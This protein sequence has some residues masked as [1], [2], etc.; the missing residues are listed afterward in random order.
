MGLCRNFNLVLFLASIYLLQ[1]PSNQSFLGF[2]SHVKILSALFI[3]ISLQF[4]HFF[5]SISITIFFYS[6]FSYFK[7]YFLAIFFCHPFVFIQFFHSIFFLS[8]CFSLRMFAIL[9]LYF[10]VTIKWSESQLLMSFTS[11]LCLRSINT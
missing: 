5:Y 3:I 1:S 7:L 6:F 10:T 11:E 9:C 2:I 4:C 8:Y